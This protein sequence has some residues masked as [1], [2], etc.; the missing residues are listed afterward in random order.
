[1]TKLRTPPQ[2]P[3]CEKHV[4]GAMLLSRDSALEGV[5]LLTSTDFYLLQNQFIFEAIKEITLN[6]G[7]PDALVVLEYLKKQGKGNY[8][9]TLLEI[10]NEVVSSVSL[11][12]H[13][14]IVRD[15]AILRGLVG[16]GMQIA[17]Y[18]YE[19]DSDGSKGLEMALSG[20]MGMSGH[21]KGGGL[22]GWRE[23][24]QDALHRW[25]RI[26]Q[27]EQ[28]GIKTGLADYDALIGG[29]LP[30]QLH[31][32]GGRPG[33][34]KSALVLQIAKAAGR[35]AIFS[36]ESLMFEQVER[37]MAQRGGLHSSVFRSPEL[38]TKNRALIAQTVASI[39]D[40]PIRVNDTTS[41]NVG[42]I[43][44]QCRKMK[45]KEGLDM[46]IV[47]YLQLVQAVGKHER[48]EREIGSISEAL[49][50]MANDLAV[51]CVAVASLSRDCERREDKRPVLSD[52]RESGSLESDAHTVTFVYQDSKYNRTIPE[53]Y[54]N[55]AELGVKK[56]KNGPTGV[57]PMLFD[58]PHFRFVDLD[59]NT[60]DQYKLF[61]NG[62][63]DAHSF[64]EGT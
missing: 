33:M 42:Q 27:G 58:G 9:E 35:T 19:N 46:V 38:L 4:L 18:A 30:S 44:S 15:K 22:K 32:I 3:D 63:N 28:T 16:F 40:Y 13:A 54:K 17:T 43:H 47:D 48:R 20:I 41:I 8:E 56:N 57:A 24:V 55:I 51:P 53:L 11:P 61:I 10:C 29:F 37:A 14:A 39:S 25:E 34:G 62:G 50:R 2:S 12:D 60:R 52:L 49:K 45:A 26:E 31:V 21:D 6:D 7:N 23:G 1:M 36:L 5:E 59:R 64:T